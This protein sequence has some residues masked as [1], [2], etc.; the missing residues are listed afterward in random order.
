MPTDTLSE[1]F[2]VHEDV[3]LWRAEQLEAA[4]FEGDDVLLLAERSDID[5]HYAAALLRRGCPADTAV[6][7]LL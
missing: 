2:V 7:I 6:R 1:S 5:L 4:G 3:L